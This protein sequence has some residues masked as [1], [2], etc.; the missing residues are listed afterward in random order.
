MLLRS[1]TK[2]VKDQNWLAVFLDFFIVVVGVFI[3]LQ[4][5]NWNDARGEYQQE[6]KALVELRKELAV[7]M[8][9]TMAQ[10]RA[11]NQAADAGKRSLSFIDGPK[12]CGD[13]CWDVIVDF[14]HASQWQNL[15]VNTASYQNMRTQG[16][17]ES[18]AIVDA[19]EAYRIQNLN[20]VSAF[21]TTPLYRSLV[22][23]LIDIEPQ[24]YYWANCW[25]LVNGIEV[26]ILDCPEGMSVDGAKQLVSEIVNNQNIK[27]HLTQWIGSIVSLPDTLGNQNNA[28]QKAIDLID[29]E[30]EGR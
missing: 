20:N 19:V 5:A 12:E 22:R 26:Y 17:P 7:S 28:A 14:M 16:F 9:Y 1:I 27:P 15:T 8:S 30:L 18:T 2:H 10:S 11:Y 24:E 13:K 4:V 23:Q 25:S 21:E 3:G 29:E 6:T